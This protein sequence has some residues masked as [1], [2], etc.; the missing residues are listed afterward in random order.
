MHKLEGYYLLALVNSE[1][2][3]GIITKGSII[4]TISYTQSFPESHS[5]RTNQEADVLNYSVKIMPVQNKNVFQGIQPT[6]SLSLGYLCICSFI[7]QLLLSIIL[8]LLFS[9]LHSFNERLSS[10]SLTCFSG[11]ENLSLPS[12]ELE[13]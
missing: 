8:S 6:P 4:Y 1:I 5:Q 10:Q 2:T 7:D 12:E 13:I 9:F 11:I 3:E